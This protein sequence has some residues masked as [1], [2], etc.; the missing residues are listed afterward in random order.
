[1]LS[2]QGLENNHHAEKSCE[3]T[4]FLSRGHGPTF[5]VGPEQEG[6]KLNLSGFKDGG[7][8]ESNIL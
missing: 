7:A 4:C 5:S 3:L 6:P 1:M 8:G 2:L